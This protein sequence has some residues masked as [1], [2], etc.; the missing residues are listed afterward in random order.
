MPVRISISNSSIFPHE[1][2]EVYKGPNNEGPNKIDVN[3][4]SKKCCSN[5]CKVTLKLF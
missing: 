4:L 1:S 3:T 5:M 2:N